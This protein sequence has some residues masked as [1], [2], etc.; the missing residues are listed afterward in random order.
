MSPGGGPVWIELDVPDLAKAEAF[1]GGLLGWTFDEMGEES[2]NYTIAKLHGDA[3]A[4]VMPVR[5]GVPSLSVYLATDDVARAAAKVRELGGQVLVEP[6]DIPGQSS[7][8]FFADPTGA[9]VGAM[10][11]AVVEL[12]ARNKPGASVWYELMTG[13]YESSKEFYAAVFGWDVVPMGEQGQPYQY[14]TNGGGDDA[15]AGICDAR[16]IIPSQVPVSFWRVYL[17]VENADEAVA[18]VA[19]LGGALIDGPMDSPFGRLATVA[20]DQGAM[21]QVIEA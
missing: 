12:E 5:E 4:G 9:V 17:G 16:E 7:M 13:D 11:S 20:D 6:V 14:A 2:G 10:Q 19:E 1:Y 8:A 15:V 3:V 21:F 18:R